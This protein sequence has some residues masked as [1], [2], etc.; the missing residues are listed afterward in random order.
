MMLLF[1]IGWGLMNECTS[2]PRAGGDPPS[3]E[4][5][6]D[7]AVLEASFFLGFTDGLELTVEVE[8]FLTAA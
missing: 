2:P 5:D 8:T 1:V 7:E 4:V 3:G 6:D